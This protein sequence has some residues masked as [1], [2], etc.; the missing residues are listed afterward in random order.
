MR[1]PTVVACKCS[2]N[3]T[4]GMRV[5]KIDGDWVR[6]WAFKMDDRAAQSEGF[7][8]LKISGSFECAP[9]YPGCPYCEGFSFYVCGRC[10]KVNC[11]HEGKKHKCGWCGRES[12]EFTSAE[13]LDLSSGGY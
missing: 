6:T 2:N 4:Y 10:G 13:K 12:S 3:K 9:G 11:Y 8:K 1:E 7:D 5:E